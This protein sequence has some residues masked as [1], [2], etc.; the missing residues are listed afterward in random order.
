MCCKVVQR[1]QRTLSHYTS[2][3]ATLKLH[4]NNVIH[5]IRVRQQHSACKRH[6]ETLAVLAEEHV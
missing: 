2:W 6:S 5:V 3:A 4:L 1:S